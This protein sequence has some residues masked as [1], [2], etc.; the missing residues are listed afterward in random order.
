M[1][2]FGRSGGGQVPHEEASTEEHFNQVGDAI[3]RDREADKVANA[4]CKRPWWKFW[5]KADR[6]TA[7]DPAE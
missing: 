4:Q 6:L 5:G 1:S 2:E 3:R 7:S